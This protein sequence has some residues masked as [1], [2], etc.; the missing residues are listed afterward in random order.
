MRQQRPQRDMTFGLLQLNYH[1]TVRNS[2]KWGHIFEIGCVPSAF[3]A[4]MTSGL[5]LLKRFRW[6][7][8]SSFRG[9]LKSFGSS[10]AAEAGNQ[11]SIGPHLLPLASEND[12]SI[13][14]ID[15]IYS[16]IDA[17][18]FL[19]VTTQNS[20]TLK[21]MGHEFR[22]TRK[23][24]YYWIM[25]RQFLI[26]CALFALMVCFPNR[27]NLGNHSP[28]TTAFISNHKS[29]HHVTIA[30]CWC[31]LTNVRSVLFGFLKS[32]CTAS[33]YSSSA[34]SSIGHSE[35]KLHMWHRKP[36]WSTKRMQ[37]T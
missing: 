1:T 37:H 21:V 12:N 35:P 23:C 29:R 31:F 33:P 7:Q 11:E 9:H 27:S 14:P 18:Y 22:T 25:E 13:H 10:F 3:E 28:G 6:V 17:V 2:P 20:D 5:P 36:L 8:L 16:I 19:P 26:C 30:T 34:R 24:D 15:W 32:K 4:A